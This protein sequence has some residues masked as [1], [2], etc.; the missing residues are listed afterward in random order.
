LRG[1]VR[2]GVQASEVGKMMGLN[3]GGGRVGDILD[4]EE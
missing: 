3:S 1:K 2:E 4:E